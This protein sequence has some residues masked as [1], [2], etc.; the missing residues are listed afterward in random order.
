[1]P[2]FSYTARDRSG[3]QTSD[4]IESANQDSAVMALRQQGLLVLKI[5]PL[6]KKAGDEKTWS[7]NPLDY[8]SITSFDVEH[9]FHQMAVML[10]SGIS[11]LDA[12]EI[13]RRY[14]RIG[15]KKVWQQIS[16]HILQGGTFTEALQEHRIFSN[17][18][19]HLIR[20]GEET[21]SL[22]TVMDQA[23]KEME[24]SRKL[25]KQI[26]GALKYPAFTLLM[27]IGLV[28]FML[29]SIVPEIKKLLK[30]MGKPMPPITQALIDVS[31]W[32]V[33]NSM[34][35][36]VGFIVSIAVFV[37]LYNVKI[38]RW[39]IDR[40]A[41]HIPVFGKVFRLAG[42]VLFCRAMG[43]L[44]SAGV[45]IIDALEIMSNLHGNKFMA[46]HVAHA[47]E[48]V[49]LGSSLADPL[50]NAGYM[51]LVMQMIKVGESSGALDEILAE[52]TEYH[53]ELLRQ[54]IAT[55]IGLIAPT[56][57]IIV[58]GIIGFV[59]AAFLVAMFS[60]AGGSPS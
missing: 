15:T 50:E 41:L 9:A 22:S 10:R 33:A 14:G 45:L 28:A 20:V 13:T 39:W 21:G 44:L 47:R 40:I 30:I 49:M 56:M 37:L 17:L 59:Y 18:I 55:L 52:M 26:F 32:F 4:I 6:K 27:A 35:L 11:L 12:L 24:I 29:T 46:S 8:R 42:T 43:L 31:D 34:I 36:L 19:V 53:D 51:P 5:A 57:T 54:A 58:G 16:D 2:F 3:Q 1:M 60:A 38:T 23:A 48:R 7:L 25:K